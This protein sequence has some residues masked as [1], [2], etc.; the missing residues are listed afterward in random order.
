MSETSIKV[1]MAQIAPVWLQRDATLD[2]AVAWI[3]DAADDGDRGHIDE[4]LLIAGAMDHGVCQAVFMRMDCFT[5]RD[6]PCAPVGLVG[7]LAAQPF[8]VIHDV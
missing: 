7:E 2:K 8:E 6:D 3:V 1:G 5:R 4:A